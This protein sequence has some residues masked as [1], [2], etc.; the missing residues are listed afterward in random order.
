MIN[1]CLA[2][3]NN[4]AKY[5]S[6]TAASILANAK[7]EDDIC[8]YIL[9]GGIEEDNKNK[10]LSLK[11]IKNCEINFIKIDDN[12]FEDYKKVK[13]HS[14][15]TLATY[16]RL[17]LSELLPFV[18]K[19]IY[20]DCDIIVN[21]S[22]DELFGT[23]LNGFA[24]GGVLDISRKHTAKNPTYI[25]AGMIVFNLEYIRKNN[26][27]EEFLNYTKENIDKIKT[28][29]QEIINE[30]LKGGRIKVLDDS[31]NVQSSNFIGR[32]SYMKNPNVVHYISKN[33]PWHFGS[34]SYHKFLWF[35]YL[36]LTPWKLKEEEKDYWYKKNKIM[37]ILLYLKH[38]PFFFLRPRFYKAFYYTYID[39]LINRGNKIIEIDKNGNT[40]R[41]LFIKGL[42]IKF[43][44]RNSTVIVHKPFPKFKS[45]RISLGDNSKI[46]FQHSK[47]RVKG[48]IIRGN[49]SNISCFVGKNFSLMS[50]CN[51]MFGKTPGI[52][53]T[54]GDDCMFASNIVLR[55][56]DGHIVRDKNTNE[57]LNFDKSIEI[58]N[59]CWVINN[60][61]IFKGVKVAHDCIIG[62]DSL[63]LKDCLE[64]NCLYAGIPAKKAKENIIWE[65]RGIRAEDLYA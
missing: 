20:F 1:I 45:C 51:I 30:V 37:S 10:I 41:K 13:T 29:D 2:S 55:T 23:D 15:I 48:F 36:E 53:V 24:L 46:E 65:R 57:I 64:P 52:K 61:K 40:K 62:S 22:L 33:K 60:A 17:K 59:N 5:L 63:V 19:I 47:Y 44:G 9:D 34:F 39:F 32:S 50:G 28:G 16:Y 12:L 31:W 54:I 56:V 7:K 26:I 11:E 8:F 6:V 18:D 25:N 49:P 43:K 35:K 3:D 42:Y 38:R 27:E 58:G 14:Y 4:Y 21:S